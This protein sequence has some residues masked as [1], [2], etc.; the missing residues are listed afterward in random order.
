MKLKI[1]IIDDEKHAS[2]TLQWQL[3]KLIEYECCGIFQDPI[4]AVEELKKNPPNLI[5][6]DI[7]MP[8]INGFQFIERLDRTDVNVVFT[9]AY[10]K[11]AVD[12]FRV[13]AIDYL[14]KPI[15]TEELKEALNRVFSRKGSPN[16]PTLKKVFTEIQSVKS[17]K[18]KIA[19][20]SV[21]GIDFIDYRDIV[22]CQSERNYTRI[23]LEDGTKKL[24][25]KTLKEIGLQ[26]PESLFFRIHHSC[27]ANLSKATGYAHNEG[28]MLVLNGK[29]ELKISR[30]KK[31]E[32]LERLVNI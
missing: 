14:I 20:P 5:F 31:K 19:V 10:G 12:A 32:L 22:Y 6:L 16:T 18:T 9:T 15:D 21:H 7:E 27:I 25:S 23:F 28:G 11:F 2:E 3:N 13:N 17:A 30:S 29:Y 1:A 24:A 8:G 4:K 26:L